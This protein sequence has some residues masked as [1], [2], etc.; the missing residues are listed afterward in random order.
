MAVAPAHVTS[1]SHSFQ[2]TGHEF[3]VTGSVPA[4]AVG[5]SMR[6]GRM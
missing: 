4:K 6:S 2:P 3:S 1:V 5:E